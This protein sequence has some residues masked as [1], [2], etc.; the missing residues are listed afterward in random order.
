MSDDWI[1]PLRLRRICI[2]RVMSYCL[3]RFHPKKSPIMP[4]FVRAL[5]HY[6]HSQTNSAPLRPIM[7][8]ILSGDALFLLWLKVIRGRNNNKKKHA[9]SCK[10]SSP[11]T[12]SKLSGP[13]ERTEPSAVIRWNYWWLVAWLMER[14]NT[15]PGKIMQPQKRSPL[16]AARGVT[17]PV[18]WQQHLIKRGEKNHT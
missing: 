2:P 7:L 15:L 18:L 10:Q 14:D 5:N 6:V 16:T 1:K 11:S 12:S 3:C 8:N 9:F 13:R 4:P 17:C